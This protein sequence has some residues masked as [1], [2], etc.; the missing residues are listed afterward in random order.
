MLDDIRCVL[1]E[2]DEDKARAW[3]DALRAAGAS[4]DQHAR[5][6]KG[7]ESLLLGAVGPTPHHVAIVGPSVSR[8]MRD[9][10]RHT[11]VGALAGCKLV[12]IDGDLTPATPRRV[13][14][15][16]AT[17]P[18]PR[19]PQALVDA[20]GG[21][22]GRQAASTSAS[23]GSDSS[24][25]VL[26]VDDN[27]VYLEDVLAGLEAAGVGATGVHSGALALEAV[28]SVTFDAIVIDLQ[29]PELDG[30]STARQLRAAGVSSTL[31][32]MVGN[33]LPRHRREA[34][35]A[36]FDALLGKPVKAPDLLA[37]LADS[38]TATPASAVPLQQPPQAEVLDMA[39][40]D[41]LRGVFGPALAR[42]QKTL[43]DDAPQRLVKIQEL[44]A[45]G[46]WGHMGREAHSL[47]SSTGTF[48]LKQVS[49][50][51]RRIER[52]CAEGRGPEAVPL[53]DEL[54]V[55]LEHGLR[56]LSAVM[57]S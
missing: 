40:L 4:V 35:A 42:V 13:E 3:G 53:V 25:D 26:V 46:D 15:W 31:V 5:A 9:A 54:A 17:L 27:P 30:F 36:G 45:A 18:V 34:T 38:S 48:G 16:G 52:T 6:G 7:L 57:A 24:S 43:E 21:V 10:Y 56:E 55:A 32:G 22:L 41:E 19:R 20:L 23:V 8:A 47:K 49:E 29:M 39:V 50:L 37:I 11:L 1:V 44:C 51:S 28:A 12:V 33:P 14:A 2:S